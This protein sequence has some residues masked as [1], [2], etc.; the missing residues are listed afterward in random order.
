MKKHH[1]VLIVEDHP[2]TSSAYKTA[3]NRVSAGNA[4]LD[5]KI[6]IVDNCDKAVREIQKATDGERKIDIVFLDINLKPSKDLTILSG[7]DLGIRIKR[8]LP[9][10]KIMIS[11][12]LYDNHRIQSIIKSIDPDGFLVKNDFNAKE[13][14]TAIKKLIAKPPYYST[15]VLQSIRQKAAAKYALDSIDRRLLFELST[16]TKM[17]DLPEVL[18]LSMAGIEKRKRHLLEVFG[19][20]KRNDRDLI[21]K[22][23]EKGFI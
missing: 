10:A 15:T 13:L 7:E 2:L 18:P 21:L 4:D 23:K 16:G 19:L 3:F 20:K 6:T 14:I 11:T 22:A 12:T 1:S 17:K 9:A 8:L 5:F